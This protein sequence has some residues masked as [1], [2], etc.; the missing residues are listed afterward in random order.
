MHPVSGFQVRLMTGWKSVSGL[1]TVSGDSSRTS[2]PGPISLGGGFTQHVAGDMGVNVQH[3]V[4]QH[5][6]PRAEEG[7]GIQ[8]AG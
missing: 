6:A 3:C 5:I 8:T 1:C 4:C 7:L 2:L